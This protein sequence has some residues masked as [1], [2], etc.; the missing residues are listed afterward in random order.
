MLNF[1]Y[2][3][4]TSFGIVSKWCMM[5]ITYQQ[6][7][8]ISRTF[9]WQHQNNIQSVIKVAQQLKILNGANCSEI[10]FTCAF[11]IKKITHQCVLILHMT[12]N[13]CKIWQILDQILDSIHFGVVA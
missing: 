11:S 7:V 12:C 6:T 4:V 10:T 5:G 9:T 1:A 13:C 2:F 8:G 3:V